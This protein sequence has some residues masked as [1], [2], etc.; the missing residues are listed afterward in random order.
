MSTLPITR[1]VELISNASEEKRK[2]FGASSLSRPSIKTALTSFDI[3]EAVYGTRTRLFTRD[4]RKAL[5][6]KRFGRIITEK[7][8]NGTEPERIERSGA[9]RGILT[10]SAE[11]KAAGRVRE[12]VSGSQ[13]LI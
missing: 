2:G 10:G 4:R 7:E 3:A 5:L 1:N 11:R 13:D 6:S 8:A 9:P 12:W